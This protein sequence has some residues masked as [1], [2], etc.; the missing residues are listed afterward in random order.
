[1]GDYGLRVAPDERIEY[2]AK[3]SRAAIIAIWAVIPAFL[4][5]IFLV[6]YLPVLIKYALNAEAKRLLLETLGIDGLDFGAV[7]NAI[8]I[9]LFGFLPVGV[10][11]VI[12]GFGAGLIALL[13]TAWAVWAGVYSYMNTRYALIITDRRILAK[14]KEQVLDTEFAPVLN[15]I[16]AQSLFGKLFGYGELNI[17][18]KTNAITVCNIA[19]VNRVRELLWTKINNNT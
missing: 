10:V 16:A 11:K 3:I 13:I 2:E 17:Q 1:M 19:E 9:E 6:A 14:A 7:R 4:L 8:Y 18:T 15:I 5:A 12:G